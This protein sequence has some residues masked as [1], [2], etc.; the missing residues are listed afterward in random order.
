MKGCEVILIHI[1]RGGK[2]VQ[3]MVA[4]FDVGVCVRVRP[5]DV[6][7]AIRERKGWYSR[8]AWYA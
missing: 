1:T 6:V 4:D 3:L 8:R 2:G 5:D 7:K